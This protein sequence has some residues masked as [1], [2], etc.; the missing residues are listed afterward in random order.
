MM[1]TDDEDRYCDEKGPLGG[2]VTITLALSL[3]RVNRRLQR[4]ELED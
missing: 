2:N 1:K 3:R 4:L